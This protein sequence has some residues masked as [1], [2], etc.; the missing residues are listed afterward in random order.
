MFFWLRPQH[1]IREEDTQKGLRVLLFDGVCT[2]IMVVLTGGAFLVAFALQLGASNVIIGPLS[3]LGPLAQI[4][5]IPAIFLIERTRLRKA[6]VVLSSFSSRLFLLVIAAAPWLLPPSLH[7][8][9]LIGSLL[10]FSGQ[11]LSPG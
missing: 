6:A 2:Q 1:Q 11:A 5:Q 10:F 4:L 9:V 3:A 8:P 7:V